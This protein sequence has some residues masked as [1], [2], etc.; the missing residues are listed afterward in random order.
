M[1]IGTSGTLQAG[2]LSG[3][4]VSVEGDSV[5]LLR[6]VNA[7]G[8]IVAHAT[9]RVCTPADAGCKTGTKG[10]IQLGNITSRNG[11]VLLAVDPGVS[12]DPATGIPTIA[13]TGMIGQYPTTQ[14]R[15]A[16]DIVLRGVAVIAGNNTA[17][18][19]IT[20]EAAAPTYLGT[21]SAPTINLPTPITI[22]GQ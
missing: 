15:A 18:K 9:N 1:N 12:I 10:V 11:G 20:V 13:Y 3:K 2:L 16:T 14:T 22:S 21:L 17:G 6:D 8:D 5:F 4:T 19:S 7:D